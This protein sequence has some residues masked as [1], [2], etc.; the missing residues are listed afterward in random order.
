MK[1][2]LFHLALQHEDLLDEIPRTARVRPQLVEAVL[3]GIWVEQA[4]FDAVLAGLN[5]VAGTHYTRD[6]LREVHILTDASNNGKFS[7]TQGEAE[8]TR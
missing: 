8:W 2:T 6:D 3:A 4:I 7:G 1:P 5:Q